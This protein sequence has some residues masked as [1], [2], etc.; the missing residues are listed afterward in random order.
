MTADNGW[1]DLAAANKNSQYSTK[2]GPEPVLNASSGFDWSPRLRLDHG[3]DMVHA[4]LPRPPDDPRAATGM[5]KSP[6]I[7]TGRGWHSWP[8][9]AC[10]PA[11]VGMRSALAR[12]AP[13]LAGRGQSARH[14]APAA[15]PASRHRPR[16]VCISSGRSNSSVPSPGL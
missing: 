16:H 13:S 3:D 7:A 2:S 6:A 12:H 5:A 15:W 4:G 8:A 1:L 10:E 11:S 14:R 9:S